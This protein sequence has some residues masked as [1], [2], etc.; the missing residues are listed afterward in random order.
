MG[1]ILL[2][3]ITAG[4]GKTLTARMVHVFLPLS[5]FG[6][7]SLSLVASGLYVTH[8]SGLSSRIDTALWSQVGLGVSVTAA[9]AAAAF[10]LLPHD[11]VVHQIAPWIQLSAVLLWS[12]RVQDTRLL[13]LHQVGR[14]VTLCH[15]CSLPLTFVLESAA[16]TAL[17][18]STCAALLAVKPASMPLRGITQAPGFVEDVSLHLAGR[19]LLPT[20]GLA[21]VRSVL[22]TDDQATRAAALNLFGWAIAGITTLRVFHLAK[23]MHD[24]SR[25]STP[26]GRMMVAQSIVNVFTVLA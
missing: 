2:Q 9:S 3:R 15:V 7:L 25:G 14:G 13:L 10:H 8:V 18:V 20:F 5:S 12:L 22:A 4:E 1:S 11:S 24:L 17:V 21:L 23:D 6:K 16:A 19:Y 26:F